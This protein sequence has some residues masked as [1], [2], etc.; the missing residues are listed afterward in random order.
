MELAAVV[1]AAL[2]LLVE[3]VD[4]LDSS[5]HSDFAADMAESVAQRELAELVDAGVV[6]QLCGSF[7]CSALLDEDPAGSCAQGPSRSDGQLLLLVVQMLPSS[8]TPLVPWECHGPDE[9]AKMGLLAQE[10]G[11]LARE[12]APEAAHLVLQ[13]RVV[14]QEGFD[15]ETG[16]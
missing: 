13:A 16:V 3:A 8:S 1:A 9:K 4:D 5:S 7:D 14:P 15:L 2:A 12:V 10:M 6:T 11:L